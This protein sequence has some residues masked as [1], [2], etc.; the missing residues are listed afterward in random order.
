MYLALSLRA[1]V[2]I[3]RTRIIKRVRLCIE[4]D[5]SESFCYGIARTR[6]DSHQDPS[7]A[8]GVDKTRVIRAEER[9]RSEFRVGT[10]WEHVHSL[11]RSAESLPYVSFAAQI[12]EASL[13]P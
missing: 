3:R 6:Y 7:A 8:F 13:G 1:I 2:R 9:S 5:R 11:V 10:V 4:T 12:V